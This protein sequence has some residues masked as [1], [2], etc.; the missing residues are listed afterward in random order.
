M[1]RGASGTHPESAPLGRL[2]TESTPGALSHEPAAA[3][4]SHQLDLAHVPWGGPQDCTFEESVVLEGLGVP[5]ASGPYA[6][7][8]SRFK[9]AQ[10]FQAWDA[11]G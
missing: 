7:D 9:I 10:P 6:L 2:A 5:S 3:P 11:A 1:T 4:L 8:W